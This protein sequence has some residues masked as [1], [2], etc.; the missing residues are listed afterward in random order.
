MIVERES[1][2]NAQDIE[3]KEWFPNFIVLRRKA[4]DNQV[5]GEWQGFVK[6]INMFCEKSQVELQQT[7]K[8]QVKLLGAQLDQGTKDATNVLQL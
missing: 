5:T 7:V 4:N 1:V 8:S 2:M 6:Q 3:N